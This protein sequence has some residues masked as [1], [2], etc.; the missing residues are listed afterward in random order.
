[1]VC[2][3]SCV[4]NGSDCRAQSVVIRAGGRA[5]VQMV[6]QIVST[7]FNDNDDEY[8]SR[9]T[10]SARHDDEYE[11]R[12]TSSAR[13]C[14]AKVENNEPDAYDE[15][16]KIT[17][18]WYLEDWVD[19]G[20]QPPEIEPIDAVRHHIYVKVSSRHP[21]AELRGAVGVS[22]DVFDEEDILD[23]PVTLLTPP[24]QVKL[25][26]H[27]LDYGNLDEGMLVKVVKPTSRFVGQSGA[28]LKQ[29]KIYDVTRCLIKPVKSGP[30]I[31]V[32]KSYLA[33]ICS[34]PSPYVL[35][36]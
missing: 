7:E 12:P 4:S 19:I 14:E 6:H 2:S 13:H 33:R 21:D 22:L 23:N 29:F 25:K 32:R 16:K 35:N 1:V 9:P 8:E 30:Y 18:N 15:I 10:S 28:L 26:P 20:P 24:I 11:S 27:E 3:S 36:D 34:D 17:N 5:K 31:L